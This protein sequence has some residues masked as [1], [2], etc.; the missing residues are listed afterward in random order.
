MTSDKQGHDK[1]NVYAD[2]IKYNEWSQEYVNR[3]VADFEENK[4][5]KVK[6]RKQT[7]DQV[8]D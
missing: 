5:R 4:R 2:D 8:I 3:F 7:L 6:K 1:F